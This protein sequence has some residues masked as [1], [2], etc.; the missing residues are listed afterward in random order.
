MN[1]EAVELGTA[2]VFLALAVIGGGITVKEINVPRIPALAR[3]ALA[4]LGIGAVVLAI[5]T[6][7]TEVQPGTVRAAGSGTGLGPGPGPGGGGPIPPCRHPRTVP[8]LADG[9]HSE[10]DAQHLLHQGGL[11]NVTVEPAFMP[12]A[13]KGVVVEIDPAPG[14]IQ[15]PRDPVIIKV[16]R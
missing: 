13:P 5:L 6:N 9:T 4:G 7:P 12:N 15:C 11:Y 10:A 14:T 3:C 16:T 8:S 2:A 1:A